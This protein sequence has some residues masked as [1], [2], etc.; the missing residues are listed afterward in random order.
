MMCALDPA[1]GGR[2]QKTFKINV[3]A[4]TAQGPG[5][6]GPRD[7]GGLGAGAPNFAKRNPLAPD[8]GREPDII[9]PKAHFRQCGVE[10]IVENK[11]VLHPDRS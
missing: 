6:I 2:T 11:S 7:A 3:L 10:D 1:I 9:A 8:S 4:T 5:L